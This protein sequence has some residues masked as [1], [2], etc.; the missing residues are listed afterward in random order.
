MAELPTWARWAASAGAVPWTV[1]IEEDVMLLADGRGTLANRADEVLAAAPPPLARSTAP[2]THACVV[3]SRTEAHPTVAGAAA[4]LAGLRGSLGA[5]LADGWDLHAAAAGTHPLATGAAATVSRRPRARELAEEMRVLA[6]REPTMGLRIHV[7]V[8]DGEKAVR[9]LDSLR[10]DLPLLLALSANSPYWRGVD[11]GFASVRT[12]LVGM[13]PRVGIPRRFGTYEE[14]VRTVDRLLRA[15]A[16]SEPELLWWDARLRPRLGTVEVRIMDAQSQVADAAALAALVHCIVCHRAHRERTGDADGELLEENRFLAARDGMAARLI[17]LRSGRRRAVRGAVTEL[18][19]GYEKLA[20]RLGC[21][22]EL[23]A[24]AA[25]ADDPGAARQR[26]QA[27]A[28]GPVALP[29]WLAG[30]F[31]GERRALAAA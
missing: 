31:T 23:N 21:A 20:A 30:E 6:R 25:L 15:D 2:A 12:P 1:A 18:L 29:A 27:E 19:A 11:S 3:E 17:D 8:P 13:F 4:E 22:A 7:T 10:A 9:A 16:L 5:W 14:Y 24:V 28:T 26:R